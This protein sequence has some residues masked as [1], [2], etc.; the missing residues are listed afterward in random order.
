MGVIRIELLEAAGD[1]LLPIS[2]GIRINGH[3]QAV[4]QGACHCRTNLGWKLQGRL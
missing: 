4:Q 1:F 3:I 2:F